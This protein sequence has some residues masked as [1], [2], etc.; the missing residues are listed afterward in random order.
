MK[1]RVFLSCGQSKSSDEPA[2][3]EKIAQRI[4][5]LGF[6][7]YVALA[8]QSLRGLRENIFGQLESSDFF[9]FIDFKRDEL[10]SGG[11]TPICRGSLFSHQELAIASFLEIPA[12]LFQERGVKPLDGMLGA[13]QANNH[14]F[15]DRAMLPSFVADHVAGK[16]REKEWR[17]DTRN[18]LSLQLANPQFTD[19]MLN[20]GI[21]CRFYH[22]AVRNNHHRKAALSCYAH[23]DAV[24]NLRTEE[25][26]RPKTIE[27]KWAGTLLPSVR[28]GPEAF[29]EFDGID[30]CL[31]SPVQPKFSPIT[32]SPDYRLRLGG[33]G[34]YGLSFSVVSH[35]FGTT[36]SD[37]LLEYGTTPESVMFDKV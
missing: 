8:E 16:L 24:V 1:A 21:N 7:C 3:A 32:D 19:A 18:S 13:M 22:I 11:G 5:G 37:F 36:P 26:T 20:T 29:R 4:N 35:T 17:T 25:V 31:T 33:P 27:I 10:K 30:F 28:I 14:E 9:V 6:D 12:L 15:S 2:L 23:L 34:K